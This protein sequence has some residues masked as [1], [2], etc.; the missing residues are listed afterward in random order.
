MDYFFQFSFIYE[1][2]YGLTVVFFKFSSLLASSTRR[3]K[4]AKVHVVFAVL[5]GFTED[6]DR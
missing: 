2:Y 5:I 1:K 3:L 6:A 4:Y